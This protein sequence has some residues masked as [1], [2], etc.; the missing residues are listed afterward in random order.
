MEED[1]KIL[2]RMLEIEKEC[3][4]YEVSKNEIKAI[5]NILNR[6]EQLEKE[7]KELDEKCEYQAK[8]MENIQANMGH[9]G[10]TKTELA[11]VCAS[12]EEDNK[13]LE[14]D[15]KNSI[16]KSVIRD[17]IE[18]L[19]NEFK[20]KTQD[21]DSFYFDYSNEYAHIEEVLKEILGDENG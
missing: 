20:E 5:E 4:H 19:E 14:E 16:P 15:L 6:L 8:F 17:K 18:E 3:L 10:M 9:K 2:K 7:N 1:I 12:L 11:F 13:E 21:N